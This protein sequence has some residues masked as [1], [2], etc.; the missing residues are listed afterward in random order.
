MND[1][2]LR[3]EYL[4]LACASIGGKD[5]LELAAV[6]EAFISARAQATPNHSS[7]MGA[8]NQ[9]RRVRQI[10]NARIFGRERFER[11]S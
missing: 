4:R 5:A 6:Y 3:L 9:F 8:T 1:K 11:G 2:D 10:H 7:S